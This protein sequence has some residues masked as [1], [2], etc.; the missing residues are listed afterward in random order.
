V[1]RSDDSKMPILIGALRSTFQNLEQSGD[2]NPND[3]VLHEI[4]RSILRTIAE[5]ALQKESID[6]EDP[7]ELETASE[8]AA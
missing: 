5:R 4:K 8:S 7:D 1:L 2:L 3:P 6:Q